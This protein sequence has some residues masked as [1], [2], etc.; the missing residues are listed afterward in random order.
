MTIELC[1]KL[2]KLGPVLPSNGEFAVLAGDNM[3]QMC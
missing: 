1:E 3:L 2:V